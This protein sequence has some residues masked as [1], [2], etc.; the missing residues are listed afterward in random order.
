LEQEFDLQL[1]F[2]DD[3]ESVTSY[4]NRVERLI[5][6]VE[7]WSVIRKGHLAFFSFTKLRMYQDLD[8]SAWPEENSLEQN[9]LIQAILEGTERGDDIP[10]Y[11][12]VEVHDQHERA[13][14]IPLVVEADSSQHTAILK[15][16]EG[17]HTVIEGPPG[18]GKSQTI[19]NIIATAIAGG[20]TVLFVSEKQAALNVVWSN[21]N[22]IGLSDFCLELHS[23][24]AR[25]DEVHRSIEQRARKRYRLPQGLSTVKSE[26]HASVQ[27]LL[28]YV[29]KCSQVGG[30]REAPLY[31]YFGTAVALREQSLPSLRAS[32]KNPP[33]NKAVFD[34]AK[35]FLS[36]FAA[37][38]S[39]PASFVDHP[40]KGF[41]ATNVLPGDD[42][43]IISLFDKLSDQI[44]ALGELESEFSKESAIEHPLSLKLIRSFKKGSLNHV[45]QNAETVDQDLITR[46]HDSSTAELVANSIGLRDK[47]NAALRKALRVL[48]EIAAV[49]PSE[50]EWLQQTTE[51]L[52]SRSCAEFSSDQIAQWL[53][54]P[55]GG[56]LASISTR[57]LSTPSPARAERTC[58]TVWI[59]AFP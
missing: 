34:R 57:A 49:N 32:F 45:F 3:G 21:L 46:F 7:R 27:Q 42:P 8:P 13:H 29:R 48:T 9:E 36:R 51:E 50:T 30:P 54:S 24:K 38:I 4:L 20:K 40:W 2:I 26:W 43:E 59:L 47:H 56:S 44:T 28:D 1:P 52:E 23:S 6:G 41:K 19:T 10:R 39:N 11:G 53:P 18:T 55:I 12:E 37:H 25:K 31:S 15:V 22:A 58:S 35:G 16:V 33:P 17:K 14:E 5:Q